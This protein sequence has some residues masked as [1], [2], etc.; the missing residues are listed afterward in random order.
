[1]NRR[2]AFD[3]QLSEKEENVWSKQERQKFPK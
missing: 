2:S 3:A 1:M